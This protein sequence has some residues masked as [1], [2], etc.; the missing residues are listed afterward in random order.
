MKC[1]IKTLFNNKE[2]YLEKFNFPLMVKV[3]LIISLTTLDLG[4]DENI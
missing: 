1:R 4:E 2:E 3:M